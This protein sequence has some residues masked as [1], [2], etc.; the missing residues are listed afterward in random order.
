MR[1]ARGLWATAPYRCELWEEELP[2]LEPGDVL[3]ETAFSAV[4]KGTEGLVL[5][6]QVP[7]SQHEAMRGPHMGGAFPFPVKYGYCLTGRVVEGA[8]PEGT[9]V[10]C[11]HPHQDRFVVP[12]TEVLPHDTPLDRA[13]LG[14]NVE[15]AL[16]AVWDAGIGPGDR[17]VV[18]GAGVVGCLV[19]WLAGGIP[20]CDVVLVDVLEDRRE[21]ARRLGVGFATP[22]QVPGHADVVVHASASE[23]GAR[24]ALEAA[25]V[26]ATVVELSWYGN[27]QI[28]VAL[29]EGFHSRRLT[30]RSSQVGRIPPGRAPRWSYRRRLAKALELAA[31]PALDVLF[32]STSSFDELP[33]ELPRVVRGQGLCHRVAY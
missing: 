9:P 16:N 5:S 7:S 4:S 6:G 20:G 26:E 8:L 3:V 28:A 33:A 32:T 10:F 19:A 15:T 29:G 21:V 11:L 27:R 18:V 30:L 13:V 22:D 14:A 23:A 17:V 1:P 2:P 12:A 24:T 31:D 25:G